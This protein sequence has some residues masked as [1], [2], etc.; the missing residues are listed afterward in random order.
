MR[1]IDP[2]EFP[3]LLRVICG[4]EGEGGDAGAGSGSDSSEGDAGDAGDAGDDGS[5]A[6]DSDLADKD[7]A[8][9]KDAITKERSNAKDTSKRLKAIEKE[10]AALKRA[11]QAVADKDKTELEKLQKAQ[12][13]STTR[14]A[15][16]AAG[17]LKTRVDA[18]IEREARAQKF[19]DPEDA[20]LQVDRSRLEV[21]QDEDDPSKVEI[22][23][24]S[25]KNAVK[26]L[27]EKKK[28]LIGTGEGGDGGS[29]GSR[30]GGGNKDKTKATEEELRRKYPALG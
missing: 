8:G 21:E 19:I 20:I 13:E 30:F 17:Y 5:E 12:A 22:D 23:G 6:D 26:A 7:L 11:Q 27:A 24:K 4:F 16:L 14:L 9:L 1:S 15:S 2:L 10:N 25:V 18:A 3:W 28:H 29:S